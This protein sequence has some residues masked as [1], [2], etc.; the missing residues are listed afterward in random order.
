MQINQKEVITI[1]EIESGFLVTGVGERTKNSVT[2]KAYHDAT[3]RDEVQ[4]MFNDI[5]KS[6]GYRDVWKVVEVE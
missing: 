4:Q 3:K 5:I 6:L 1:S 2:T